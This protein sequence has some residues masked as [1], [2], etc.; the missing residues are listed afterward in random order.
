MKTLPV[1]LAISASAMLVSFGWFGLQ[2]TSSPQPP[3]SAAPLLVS[4][5]QPAKD[6]PGAQHQ[7]SKRIVSRDEQSTRARPETAVVEKTRI[8]RSQAT[9]RLPRRVERPTSSRSIRAANMAPSDSFSVESPSASQPPTSQ[10]QALTPEYSGTFPELPAVT[11]R[12]SSMI[13]YVDVELAPGTRVPV[14]L[15]ANSED[16]SPAMIEAK[17]Q[18]AQEFAEEVLQATE[19]GTAKPEDAGKSWTEAQERADRRF[20]LFYGKDAYNRESLQAGRA[21]LSPGRLP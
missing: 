2:S 6:F 13:G 21:E 19:N 9:P 12:G 15:S 18:I 16:S 8:A 14:A 17:E 20:R 3:S 7:K 10:P 1:A 11:F 5:Q 4:L